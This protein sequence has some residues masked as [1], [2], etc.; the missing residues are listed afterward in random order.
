MFRT[1]EFVN[2]LFTTRTVDKCNCFNI[3]YFV[4]AE[5]CENCLR[6]DEVVND[7]GELK[8]V[9][10]VTVGGRAIVK[11]VIGVVMWESK[12]VTEMLNY[13]LEW[14]YVFGV[15]DVKPSMRLKFN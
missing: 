12:C 1:I 3:D 13:Q 5:R 15:T 14:C 9:V 2:G 6:S 8:P 10:V 11:L 7:S 4:D